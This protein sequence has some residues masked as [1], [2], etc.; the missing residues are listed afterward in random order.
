MKTYRVKEINKKI[1]KLEFEVY[2]NEDVLNGNEPDIEFMV[3][4]SDYYFE[5]D[6]VYITPEGK[7]GHVDEREFTKIVKKMSD[8]RIKSLSNPS[9]YDEFK[10]AEAK[11]IYA[12][13]HPVLVEDEDEYYKSR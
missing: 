8:A 10:A 4:N 13:G 7:I 2:M 1:L 11:W 9:Y 5:D 6:W 3:D 12:L